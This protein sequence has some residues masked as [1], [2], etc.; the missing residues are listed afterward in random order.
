MAQELS[1]SIPTKRIALLDI[2]RGFAL[3]GVF[4]VNIEYMSASVI[5]PDAFTW[6]MEGTA[7][8]ITD[9]ILVNFFNGKFFP[10]FSFLFGV[11]FGMQLNKMEEKGS[12][13]GSFFM[14][15][16]FFLAMFGLVHILFIWGGDVLLLYSLAGFLVLVLRR[17]PVKWIMIMAFAILLFPFYGHILGY[18]TNWYAGIGYDIMAQPYD[19]DQIKEIYVNGNLWDR[20]YFRLL[21]YT[22]YYRNAE[23]FPNLLFMIFCGYAAG[24]YKFYQKIPE[25][26]NKLSRL[27]LIVALVVVLFRLVHPTLVSSA[28]G[29]FKILLDKINI[30]CNAGQAFLYLYIISFLYEKRIL[31]K[32]IEPLAYAG[33]M[34]LTNY[35]TQSL[36]GM[37]L[38]SG[39]FFGLYGQLSIAYLVLISLVAYA[40]MIAG[41]KYWTTKFRYGPLEYIWRELTYKVHL[42]FLKNNN[43]K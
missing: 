22:V 3:L 20:M 19:Y 9:W 33:R 5:H 40:L 13:S 42:K 2:F 28:D 6:M 10:I 38:F 7:N 24:R 26:L 30:L 21:E 31:I 36:I 25:T 27:A 11:G 17:V 1:P 34:S 8:N 39:A 41:S 37:I 15:R 32:L 43:N 16:Y 14:R 12:F 35:I 29:Y 18:V 23:Y 4:V